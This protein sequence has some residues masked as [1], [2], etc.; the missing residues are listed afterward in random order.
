MAKI[1]KK[2]H[3]GTA[4]RIKV[5]WTGKLMFKK[6]GTRHLLIKKRKSPRRDKYGRVLDKSEYRKIKDLLPYAA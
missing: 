4:K 1:K 2:T 3:K 6:C 5:T